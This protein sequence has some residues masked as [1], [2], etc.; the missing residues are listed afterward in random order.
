VLFGGNVDGAL[1][2]DTWIWDGNRWTQNT[3]A[4]SPSPR[5][6]PGMARLGGNVVLFGGAASATKLSP[7]QLE[8]DAIGA[9]DGGC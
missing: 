8:A 7:L 4:T 5:T 1:L 9:G 3:L 6:D 2:G